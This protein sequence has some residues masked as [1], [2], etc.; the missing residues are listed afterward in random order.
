MRKEKVSAFPNQKVNNMDLSGYEI[1]EMLCQAGTAVA[2]TLE[3]EEAIE[4]ILEQLAQVVP[5][6]SATV[7]LLTRCGERGGA[8]LSGTG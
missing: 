4:R 5:Y 1:A 7:Q 8:A 3:R 6:D 2:A